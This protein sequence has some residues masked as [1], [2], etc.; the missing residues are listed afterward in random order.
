MIKWALKV[1][2]DINALTNVKF[3]DTVSFKY[4]SESF[5]L[6]ERRAIGQTHN[7]LIIK[8]RNHLRFITE[9][10]PG[11]LF[12]DKIH[13]HDC[14]EECRVLSGKLGDKTLIGQCFIEDE[15]VKYKSYQPHHPYNMSNL[16]PLI[17]QVDFYRRT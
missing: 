5:K 13:M 6:N 15:I 1:V 3:E 17:I 16:N 10:P 2:E 11:G 8:T 4:L 14:N 12:L 7:R 9:I